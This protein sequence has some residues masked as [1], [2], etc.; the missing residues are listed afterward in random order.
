MINHKLRLSR[1]MT[2]FIIVAACFIVIAGRF[3]QVQVIQGKEYARKFR[4][5][6]WINMPIKAPRGAIYDRNGNPLAYTTETE[7]L[8]VYTSSE[9]TIKKI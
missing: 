7:N 3:F 8:F 6:C 5:L 1:F 9:E 4:N 2:F